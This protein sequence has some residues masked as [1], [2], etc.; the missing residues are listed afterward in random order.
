MKTIKLPVTVNA[1]KKTYAPGDD[2]PINKDFSQEDA[3]S[4]IAL[5]GPFKSASP[6]TPAAK[7]V[8]VPVADLESEVVKAALEKAA[9][10]SKAAALAAAADAW[11]AFVTLP[12]NATEGDID[13]AKA[14]VDTALGL[15][16]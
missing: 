7:T 3:A 5:H 11:Q 16:I 6:A 1:G 12:E 4:L 14:A 10:D 8:E 2:V 15:S 13:A 9:L